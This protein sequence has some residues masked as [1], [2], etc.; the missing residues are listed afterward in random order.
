MSDLRFLLPHSFLTMKAN[1]SAIRPR[2]AIAY[3]NNQEHND[4]LQTHASITGNAMYVF[5][6]SLAVV[7]V[8]PLSIFTFKVAANAS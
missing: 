7:Y 3:N 4:S 8:S 2:V 6:C 5:M 1:L